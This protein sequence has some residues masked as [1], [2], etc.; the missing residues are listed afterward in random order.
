MRSVFLLLF[1][2]IV[3]AQVLPNNEVLATAIQTVQLMEATAIAVPDLSKAATPLIENARQASTNLQVRPNSATFNYSLLTTLRAYLL[4]ADSIPKP[5]PFPSAASQQFA[6]LRDILTRFETHFRALVDLKETQLRSPDPDNLKRYMEANQTQGPVQSGRARVVFLGDSITDSWRLNEY[7]P[8]Q[9]FVNRGISGQIT[10]QMLLRFKADVMDLHPEAV[11]ILGGTNDLS[12]G[13]SV[14]TIES[15]IT[16][17]ADLAEYA[18]IKVI[19][20]SVLPVSDYHKDQNVTYERTKERSPAQIRALNEWLRNF[21]VNR[22]YTYLDYYS[23]T[24][25][26]S[27]M[28]KEDLSADGLHPNSLGYRIMGPLAQEAIDK[29][30]GPGTQQKPKRRRLF[31]VGK[32][33]ESEPKSP[34]K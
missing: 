25:D 28:L 21:C 17:L 6:L 18:K 10:G 4:L 3:Q 2:A 26:A 16:L 8:D 12:R 1:A 19:L 5:F 14:A 30:V 29:T 13:I 32:S 23:K 24:V 15:N 11:V 31:S 20:A 9:D 7:F 22:G 27:G 33:S 34:E